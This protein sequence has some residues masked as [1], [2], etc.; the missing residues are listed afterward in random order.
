VLRVAVV[1]VVLVAG[2]G[3]G[4]CDTGGGWRL[5]EAHARKPRIGW[6]LEFSLGLSPP[7]LLQAHIGKTCPG[8]P[9]TGRALGGVNF[10]KLD[11]CTGHNVWNSNG[12]QVTEGLLHSVF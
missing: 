12:V 2:N 3:H 7:N 9:T 5:L 10:A 1:V 11:L 8:W 4:N 6:P